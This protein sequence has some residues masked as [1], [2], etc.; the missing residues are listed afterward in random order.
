MAAVSEPDLNRLFAAA[1]EFGSD[2]R[3][4][5]DDL[6]TQGG[7]TTD[8]RLDRGSLS[9]DDAEAPPSRPQSRAVLRLARPRLNARIC[10]R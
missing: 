9:V 8:G 3:A 10:R 7:R 4:P 5:V 2:W 6:A 1:L